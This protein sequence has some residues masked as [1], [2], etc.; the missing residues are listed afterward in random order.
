VTPPKDEEKPVRKSLLTRIADVLPQLSPV[1]QAAVR[2]AFAAAQDPDERARPHAKGKI[3]LAMGA[4]EVLDQ[5][6]KDGQRITSE[7]LEVANRTGACTT[8][9]WIG[10]LPIIL[11][12]LFGAMFL[13][14]RRRGG[15]K[16]EILTPPG[17]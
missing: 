3:T 17:S 14:D 15:Y 10:V 4:P 2:A 7:A 8:F 9:R 1:Q 5:L 11:V 16:Q 6:A 13:H 12:V